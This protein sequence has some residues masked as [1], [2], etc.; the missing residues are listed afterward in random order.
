MQGSLRSLLIK[1][2][3]GNSLSWDSFP[4]PS[5]R[6][7]NFPIP[8]PVNANGGSSSPIPVPVRG[9]YPRRVPVPVTKSSETEKTG[10]WRI[11][12]SRNETE[13]RVRYREIRPAS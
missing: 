2:S 5:P 11:W 7:K 13:K 10:G 1:M 12:G 3:T 9:F 8:I 6:G 4:S